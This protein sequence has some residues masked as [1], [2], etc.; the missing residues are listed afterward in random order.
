MEVQIS[1]NVTWYL[2]IYSSYLGVV[3]TYW[4]TKLDALSE[5]HDRPFR[6]P[7]SPW[8]PMSAMGIPPFTA[9]E[10]VNAPLLSIVIH[11]YPLLSIVIHCL[12]G[13]WWVLPVNH[14]A[15]WSMA[16]SSGNVP[17]AN[18]DSDQRL[19]FRQAPCDEHSKMA[20]GWK[21]VLTYK[22]MLYTH[23]YIYIHIIL[24]IYV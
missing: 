11:C 7:R 14:R 1:S 13:V 15:K 9:I 18:L 17:G 19:R 2:L 12:V 24:Y 22:W 23:T 6:G 10:Q 20:P 5:S 3:Q 16:V 21:N 4:T 8:L